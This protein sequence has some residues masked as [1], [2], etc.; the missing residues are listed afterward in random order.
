MVLLRL[1]SG[2]VTNILDEAKVYSSHAKKDS[3][4]IDDVK[5]AIQ[6]QMDKSFTTPPP[7]DLLVEI[8]KQR[9]S[10]PLP[11]LKP[12]CGPKLPPDRYCLSSSNYKLKSQK[13]KSAPRVQLIPSSRL[14]ISSLSSVASSGSKL[15]P[16]INVGSKAALTLVTKSTSSPT[17]A[18]V[19][20]PASS[21]SSTKTTAPK[22]LFRISQVPAPSNASNTEKTISDSTGES[23]SANSGSG[24]NSSTTLVTNDSNGIQTSSLKRKRDD[25]DDYDA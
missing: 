14:N 23:A 22:P 17:V 9:N 12:I 5:L 15:S 20:R 13:S 2:Y 19:T 6:L 8:A 10:M 1:F 25:D 7:R 3:L 4:D 11:L 18:I 21:G 24:A 16:A